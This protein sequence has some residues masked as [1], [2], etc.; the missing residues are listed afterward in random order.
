[1]NIPQL[2]Q[3]KIGMEY[4]QIIAESNYYLVADIL[5]IKS[6]I[7]LKRGYIFDFVTP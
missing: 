5:C 4:W 6:C 7:K 2:I 1:M 3:P